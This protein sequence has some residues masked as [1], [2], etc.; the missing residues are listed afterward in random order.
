MIFQSLVIFLPVFFN[1]ERPQLSPPYPEF[2][3]S[4]AKFCSHEHDEQVCQVS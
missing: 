2:K 3:K 4:E 1:F